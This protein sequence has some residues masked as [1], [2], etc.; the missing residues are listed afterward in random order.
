MKDTNKNPLWVEIG[1]RLRE[2]R[3]TK[4]ETQAELGTA[5]GETRSL[6]NMWESGERAIKAEALLALAGHFGCTVDY[7][8]CNS[9]T[10][11]PAPD[12][13]AACKVLGL[14]QKSVENIAKYS[15]FTIND[16]F[17]S[18][19]HCSSFFDAWDSVHE[20]AVDLYRNILHGE[21]ED[22]I[23]LSDMLQLAIFRLLKTIESAVSDIYNPD[24]IIAAAKTEYE[25]SS[26][27]EVSSD[28]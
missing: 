4:G 27:G 10:Q 22:H 21:H 8:L 28:G 2:L 26:T 12:M 11:S 15:G 24:D 3:E 25:V 19:E 14:S 17:E 18:D 23:D 5:I 13:Q 16:L 9:D 7:I 6:V 1:N 20:E